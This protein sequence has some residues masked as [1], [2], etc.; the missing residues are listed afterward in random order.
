MPMRDAISQPTDAL[1]DRQRQSWLRGE[2][3]SV[4]ALLAGTPF[5]NDAEAQLDLVYNEIVLQEELGLAISINDY[6][7]RFPHL[8]QDLELHFEVH[9]ALGEQE[10]LDTRPPRDDDSRPQSAA[11]APGPALLL[12]DYEIVRPLGA[13][14]MAA[15]YLARDRRLRRDVALK[16][17]RPGRLLK[18]RELFRIR[19]EAEA[20]ARLS[21]PNI[22]Q[23]FEI[24]ESGGV[25]YLVLELAAQGTLSQKLQQFPFAPRAAATLIVTLARALQHAHD[26]QVIHRDLK[27]ANVLFAADGTPKVTDFGLAKVLEDR[28]VASAEATRTGEA[29][30]TPRYMAPEQA[31]GRHE[32]VGAATDVYALGTLLYECLTG[33]APFVSASV[34]ETLQRIEVEDPLAPRRLQTAVPR[35]LET[36]CLHCLEKSPLRRYASAA[37]LA[38]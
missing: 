16:V 22:V 6:F 29:L 2:R 23:I 11:G 36:I 8:K 18:P 28:D 7:C 3:P 25:P 32:R 37:E 1:L 13:G 14:A 9:R 33:Q 20:I 19:T 34:A 26:R 24:G 12:D 31:A 5:E 21:H 15:V 38:D 4:E 35:D 27:P 17:F 10:L 30:G